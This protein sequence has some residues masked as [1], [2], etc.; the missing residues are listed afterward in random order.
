M[1]PLVASVEARTTVIPLRH[2]R[3]HV[4]TAT[5]TATTT[6]LGLLNFTIDLHL[7]GTIP[8][9][10]LEDRVIT[11]IKTTLPQVVE[12]EVGI[13]EVME[14]VEES[15]RKMGAFTTIQI[16]IDNLEEVVDIKELSQDRT[17]LSSYQLGNEWNEIWAHFTY[18]QL[19]FSIYYT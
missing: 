17:K 14:V 6:T 15:R 4:T 18:E 16:V 11:I 2:Y 9:T 10:N 7:I 13:G 1:N 12:E 5:T 8:I 19:V 3:L